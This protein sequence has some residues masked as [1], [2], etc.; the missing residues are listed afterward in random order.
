MALVAGLRQWP[1]VVL[2]LPAKIDMANA[3]RVG[4]QL[5]S[6]LAA[7]V[8]TVIADMTATRFCDSCTVVRF[9]G[10]VVEGVCAV[11]GIPVKI[12]GYL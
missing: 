11:T 5:G 3:G 7:G 10:W 6:A 12:P 1:A 9:R 4:Q 2:A 8:K